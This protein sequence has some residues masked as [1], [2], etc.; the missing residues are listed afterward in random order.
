MAD[1]T[2][3]VSFLNLLIVLLGTGVASMSALAAPDGS[4]ERPYPQ[5]DQAAER[6]VSTA[7]SALAQY[8]DTV[9]EPLVAVAATEAV[10]PDVIE[11]VQ[12]AMSGTGER[13]TA[14]GPWLEVIAKVQTTTQDPVYAAAPRAGLVQPDIVLAIDE[15]DAGPGLRLVRGALLT[16]RTEDAEWSGAGEVVPDSSTSVYVGK[17]PEPG[18]E[19]WLTVSGTGFC[20]RERPQ[21][22]WRYTAVR[23]AE[24]SARAALARARCGET[25]EGSRTSEGQKLTGDAESSKVECTLSA[26]HVVSEHFDASSCR[27]VVTLTDRR[28]GP[29]V[30]QRPGHQLVVVPGIGD[31]QGHLRFGDRWSVSASSRGRG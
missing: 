21:G 6:V 28:P 5:V 24:L 23:A 11:A 26:T 13:Q 9:D 2:R 8:Q 16:L 4:R 15:A 17:A 18:A 29:G 20:N 25:V 10:S 14:T 30:Q 12:V 27:A 1:S 31:H 19:D 7:R 3:R 22:T